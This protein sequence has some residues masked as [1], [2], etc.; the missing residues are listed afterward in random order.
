MMELWFRENSILTWQP[1]SW[2]FSV[3]ITLLYSL[4]FSLAKKGEIGKDWIVIE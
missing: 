4:S 2:Q 1:S 3:P